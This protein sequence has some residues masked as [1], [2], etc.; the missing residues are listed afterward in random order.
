MK[1]RAL[2]SVFKK[3]GIVDF[4]KTLIENDWEII[5]TGGTF[6]LLTEN[7]IPCTQVSDI[8]G[9]PEIMNGRV[10]TLHP[11]IH[12]AILAV[13]DNESHITQMKENDI[14]PIDMIVVNLYP[15]EEVIKKVD[16]TF[17][18]AIEMIDIGGPTMIRSAAKNFRDVLVITDPSMYK[19]VAL[20][21]E[22]GE[23]FDFEFRKMLAMKVFEKTAAY[24]AA[25]FNYLSEQQFP[26]KLTLTAEKFMDLRYGE[27]PHQKAAIYKLPT[28]DSSSLVNAEI[29][30]GKPLSYNNMMDAEACVNLTYSFKESVCTIMKHSNPCGVGLSESPKIAYKRALKTDPISAFGSIVAFNRKIDKDVAL[31]LKTAFVEVLIAPDYEDE[32]LEIL[33]KKKNLR[34]LRL[35]INEFGKTKNMEYRAIRGGL[36]VQEMDDYIV[37]PEELKFVTDKKPTSEQIK[38]LLFAWNVVKTVKSNAIVFA[39]AEGTVGVGAGQMSRVDSVR[40]AKEK[41][42]SAGFDLK[43]AVLASDAFFPFRDSIDEAHKAGVVAVIQPGGSIRDQEVID[44]CNEHGIAMVFTGIRHFRH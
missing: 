6:K 5:S 3:D 12:G 36:L 1:K 26:E 32:A 30:G 14:H 18:E 21:I 28:A 27:N 33:K 31:E 34:I 9:F 16:T 19:E 20:K 43:G 2:I 41:A 24:D 37:A 8:T 15:F 23:E 13:R 7:D 35:P 39:D 22:N 4:A 11:K 25:I 40:F 42:E 17:E 10:K 38:T 29:L 44:A